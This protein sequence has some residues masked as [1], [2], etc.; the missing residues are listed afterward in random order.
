MCKLFYFFQSSDKLL[1]TLKRPKSKSRYFFVWN[2]FMNPFK[3]FTRKF[4]NLF[5]N[6]FWHDFENIFWNTQRFETISFPVRFVLIS[7]GN[8]SSGGVEF[9]NWRNMNIY[10]NLPEFSNP[11]ISCKLYSLTRKELSG[12]SHCTARGFRNRCVIVS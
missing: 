7:I 11:F 1:K 3:G 2:K 6:N 5:G 9:E 10:E 8:L 12:Y 4:P